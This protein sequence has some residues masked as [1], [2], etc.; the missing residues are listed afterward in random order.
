[1][2]LGSCT[3]AELIFSLMIFWWIP[4]ISCTWVLPCACGGRLPVLPRGR[5]SSSWALAGLQRSGQRGENTHPCL[6]P[7]HRGA[8]SLTVECDGNGVFHSCPE[9]LRVRSSVPHLLSVFITFPV[10][11]WFLK[12]YLHCFKIQCVLKLNTTVSDQCPKTICTFVWPE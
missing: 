4:S 6:A 3:L 12:L 5:L 2:S 7:R 9:M 1:M 11:N 10:A 8:F